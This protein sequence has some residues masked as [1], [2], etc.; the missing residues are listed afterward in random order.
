MFKNSQYKSINFTANP[1]SKPTQW[2]G[3]DN[4]PLIGFSWNAGSHR[5]TSGIAIWNDAFLHTTLSGNEIA[6]ILLDTPGLEDQSLARD[7]EIFTASLAMSSMQIFYVDEYLSEKDLQM[8]QLAVDS[9]KFVSEEELSND[10]D[11]KP[12]QQLN[13][14]VRDWVRKFHKI[15]EILKNSCNSTV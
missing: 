6:I 1:L 3:A 9:V 11:Y 5:V 7:I 12:F 8:L 15:E 10:D 13:F 4:D 14:I 2:L